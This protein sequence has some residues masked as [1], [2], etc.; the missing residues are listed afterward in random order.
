LGKGY[1]CCVAGDGPSDGDEEVDKP[2]PPPS[3]TPRQLYS[4][5]IELLYLM[6]K[7]LIIVY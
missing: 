2:S 7:K 4:K 3:P 1:S 5:N 6:I